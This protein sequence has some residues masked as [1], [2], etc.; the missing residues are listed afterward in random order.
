MSL[1]SKELRQERTKLVADA[2]ALLN[3]QVTAEQRSKFDRMMADAEVMKGD[4]DRIEKLDE[5]A[6]ELRS[7]VTPPNAQVGGVETADAKAVEARSKKHAAAFRSYLLSG[8]ASQMREFRDNTSPMSVG[9][10][11]NGGYFVPQGFQYEIETALKAFGG[12]REV[13]RTLPTATGNVLPWPNSNDTGTVGEILAENTQT[14][15]AIASI[16]SINLNAYKYSTKMVNVSLE[17]LQDSAFDIEAYLKEQ[18]VIR[19]GRIT[20]T[21]FTT[22]DG[23]SKPLG[24]LAAANAAVQGS[25]ITGDTTNSGSDIATVGYND[26]INLEHSVDPSYRKDA[27]YMFADSTLKVIK[28]LKDTLGR[29][30]FVPGVAEKSPDTILGYKFTVNQDMAALGSNAKAMLFGALNKYVIRSV[31]ELSVV[32]L[33]E[34]FADFGQVAFLGFARYDGKL[35]DAGT[36]PVKYAVCPNT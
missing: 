17:L 14:D 19:I 22:G 33:S 3:G 36:H 24:I 27:S 11:A 16:G 12:M 20:N 4:I 25:V 26:L 13:A 6:E 2:Q 18:F 9:T 10:A 29:P 28:Q 5:M 8:D 1:R 30:L 7:T 35:L 32:R 21:H 34:R 31:K 23:S 15:Q